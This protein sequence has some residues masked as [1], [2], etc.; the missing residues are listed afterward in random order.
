M[1]V[2]QYS[3][4]WFRLAGQR[5]ALRPHVRV[6]RQRFRGERWFVLHDP[7]T[8]QFFRLR[9]AAW[10]FVARLGLDRTIDAVWTEVVERDPLEAPGQEEALRLLAQLYNANLL[11]STIAPDTAKLF[12]RYKKRRQRETRQLL[13]NI[14]FARIPLLDPDRFLQAVLPAARRIFGLVG[15]IAWSVVVLGA[16]KV[17]IDHAGELKLQG[18]GILA[19]GNLFWLYV[20]LVAAKLIHEFGHAIA[21]R[22]YGGEVHTMGVM[23]LLFT[24]VPY[25]D[26]TSSWS[27]RDR[28]H[29]AVVGAAGMYAELFLAAL[30]TFVWAATGP[31][32]LN[33]VM[34]NLMFVASVS[35]I[36]FNGNPLL[37]FDGYYILSD[38]LDIPN[39][40][41]RATQMLH[42]L[43]ERYAFGLKS[44]KNPARSPRETGWLVTF[45]ITSNIYRIIV[46]VLI[47]LFLADRYLILGVLL[48]VVCVISWLIVPVVR[49]ITYLASSPR[50]DRVRLRAVGVTAGTVAFLILV[51][52]VIPWPHHFRAPGVV[53]STEHT[54]IMPDTP[55]ILREILA[56]SGSVVVAGQPLFRLESP[57]LDMDLVEARAQ[58]EETR[59]RELRALQQ[60]TA[61]VAPL[62]SRRVALE[63]RVADLE[64]RR[65]ALLV[66]APHAG[67]WIAPRLAEAPGAWIERGQAVGQ[68]INGR[69]TRFVAVVS[70]TD[71]ARLFEGSSR[72]AEVRLPGDAGMV[73]PVTRQMIIPADR[74]TLPAPALGWRAGGS[75]P[76]SSDDQS[77]TKAAEPFFEVRAVLDAPSGA[78]AL[79]GRSGWMRYRL[80]PEPLF[81]Q[82]YRSFR[83]LLQKR[84][85]L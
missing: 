81:T 52:G 32:I 43:V 29:R 38:L 76:V 53:E 33:S 65:E 2:S 50:I 27:F 14:M 7:F 44:S 54:L 55:G 3:E 23:F 39:L 24:P 47:L 51:L 8:N 17:A 4:S 35:T 21:C 68:V 61:D 18:Q 46:L 80:P 48:T 60:Q 63:K 78:A 28:G 69:V 11:H 77:G 36:L 22:R 9:P 72:P 6:L 10:E 5:V 12:D 84:Y 79:Q 13:Q 75:V 62:G 56:P 67:D 1:A 16:I 20:A 41:Q 64:A 25:V 71:A 73:L 37:R 34:F 30:A 40:H 59:V 45:A 83:Q 31:G 57:E 49:F 70:Q 82:A 85:N 15:F 19:Y 66:R 58:V 74:S 26:V 42:H